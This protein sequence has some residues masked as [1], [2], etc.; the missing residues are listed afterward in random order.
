MPRVIAGEFRKLGTTRLWLWLLLASVGI[1]TLYAVLTVAFAGAQDT[2]TLPL[3]TPQGQR[4][5][6]A[7]GGGAAPFA[8][9]LGAIGL[10]AEY[11]HRTATPTFLATP[12][13]GRVVAAKL[14]TYALAGAGYAV[15]CLAVTAAIA[16]P[17]L[18]SK[19]V[20]FAV[21]GGDLTAT[22]AGVITAVTVFGLLGVGLGAL[23]REQVATVLVLLIYLFVV[24]NILTNIPAL[25]RWTPWLP[26]QAE[27]A[28]VGSTLTNQD[29]LAPWQGGLVLAG[30]G[31]LLAVAGTLL[32]VRRD[33]T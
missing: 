28:L 16:L 3:S 11:R 12:H 17:W 18:A 10:T 29:L 1:T 27:E 30:Y 4:T 5:L 6:L 20:A 15:V 21:A 13:R 23:L 9:V 31:I 33:V 25:H 24:E 19:H 7:V 26:G 8:A 22:V 14:V 32:T 2:F